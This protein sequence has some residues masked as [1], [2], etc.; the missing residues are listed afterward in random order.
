MAGGK[1][2]YIYRF[3]HK[4]N[5]DWL[6][7]NGIVSAL[8][9]KKMDGYTCV[10]DESIISSRF[11][12]V[13]PWGDYGVLN[14]YVPF[15]FAPRSPMLY[16]IHKSKGPS[17]SR[18]VIYLVTSAEKIDELS[19]K[20]T[21]TNSHPLTN[22]ADFFFSLTHLSEIDWPL[23]SSTMWNDTPED[24]DRHNRRMAEF[25][26]RDE[27]PFK[28]L[29]GIGVYSEEQK[30]YVQSL[31]KKNNLELPVVVAPRWYY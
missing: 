11:S 22:L 28:H 10:G 17:V 9:P 18:N 1:K 8:N 21:Y 30:T 7:Q 24:N 19:I 31:L 27:L 15:Y 14:D 25:L 13:I 29:L 26:V 23:M 6:M 4:N 12:K 20:Y 5:L 16:K 2:T 3:V